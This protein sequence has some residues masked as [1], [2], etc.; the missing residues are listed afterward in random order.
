MA[1]IDVAEV[2]DETSNPAFA[3]Q[4]PPLKSQNRHLRVVYFNP[5]IRGA[6]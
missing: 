6:L 4:N 3:R 1:A 5:Q 2:G